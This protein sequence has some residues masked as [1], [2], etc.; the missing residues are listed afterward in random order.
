MNDIKKYPYVWSGIY[1]KIDDIQND[2]NVFENQR[3]INR[4]IDTLT[5][6]RNAC[7]TEAL[8]MPPR[9]SSLPML[10]A[11]TGAKTI[12]DFGGSSGWVYDFLDNTV[13][14][15][16]ITTYKI[17]ELKEFA[18]II[19]ENGLHKDPVS[20]LTHSE[21]LPKCDI[22]YANSAIQYVYDDIE[23]LKVIEESSAEWILIEDFLGGSFD[24]FFTLQKYYEKSIPVKFR[25]R[26]NFVGALKEYDLILSQPYPSII[27][28]KISEFPMK[29]FPKNKRIKFSE[30]M[31]FKKRRIF[32][33]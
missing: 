14:T 6:Y 5:S 16:E 2:T 25:N 15:S 23:L 24:D 4:T 19:K 10:V 3:W 29:N 7:K 28:E 1:K 18:K 11:S 31:L 17:I 30:T 12:I 22:F 27:F 32:D 33:D 13:D 9:L 21:A 26:E 20:Y 8:V